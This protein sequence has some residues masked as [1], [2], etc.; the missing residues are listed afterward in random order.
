MAHQ[1]PAAQAQLASTGARPEPVRVWLLGGFKVSVG[2]RAVE[3]G[4]WRLRKAETLVK[5]LAL[6]R[7]H[8]LHRERLMEVLWPDLDAKSAS[9]NLH[10][11]LHFARGALRTGPSNT[12][13]RYPRLQGDLIALCPDGQLWVD[14]DTFEEAAA[15]A[16][17]SREPTA[18]RAALD[19]YA[20]DLLPEDRYEEWAENRREGLRQLYLALLVELAGLHEE[21]RE[22]ADGI[23]AL[24]RVV[25]EE[26]VAEEAHAALIRLFALSGQRKETM[27]QY[28]R[29]RGTLL[30]ELDTV[31]GPATQRL[32]EQ[33]R[34]GRV[35]DEGV[36]APGDAARPTSPNNL[37]V[38]LT[39][40]VGRE[41]TLVEVRRLLSMT[42]L[43][44]LTG[45]GVQN[46]DESG[47]DDL[48]GEGGNDYILNSDASGTDA[49]SGGVGNDEI[50][51]LGYDDDRDGDFDFSGGNDTVLGG[52]G[53]DTINVQ[54]EFAGDV[55]DCGENAGG[56][57]TNPDADSVTADPG[58]VINANCEG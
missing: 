46:G 36:G 5:L 53:N 8:R 45:A 23:E 7:G 18:Y 26:P 32:Y 27:L 25:T 35:L 57:A 58:D 44:T 47:N 55:V 51:S 42:R 52:E 34:A 33:V 20:G 6:A 9:N 2:S 3:S 38:S 28:E 37:P 31:P 43:L 39:S 12:T 50:E 17:R 14:V 10:R 11:A 40:F 56:D 4:S 54:D 41:R 29:L 16:R 15:T 49:V 13:S 22:Y 21:R 30:R 48:S 24:R 19:L 1:R